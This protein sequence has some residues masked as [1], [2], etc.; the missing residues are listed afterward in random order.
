[1]TVLVQQSVSDG[2]PSHSHASKPCDDVETVHVEEGEKDD[3]EMEE[4]KEQESEK[5]ITKEDD[6]GEDDLQILEEA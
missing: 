6:N 2:V 3:E 4:T 1:M 5:E